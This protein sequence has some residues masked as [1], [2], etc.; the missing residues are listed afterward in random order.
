MRK[1]GL[2]FCSVS[3]SLCCYWWGVIE[4]SGANDDRNEW[5][6]Y[7]SHFENYSHLT[8]H[9]FQAILRNINGDPNADYSWTTARQFF[10]CRQFVTLLA[11]CTKISPWSAISHLE[12]PKII[13][14]LR[15][16]IRKTMFFLFLGHLKPKFA[17]SCCFS[18]SN[19]LRQ[20]K[21]KRMKEPN[22][23]KSALSGMDEVKSIH[24]TRTW[25]SFSTRSPFTR[26]THE[27]YSWGN[28]ARKNWYNAFRGR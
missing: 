26:G 1:K 19:S 27:S 12:V 5:T 15:N 20:P 25:K 16:L 23:R 7:F 13:T 17:N 4:N 8:G 9:L 10:P 22:S 11:R 24:K 2:D 3:F 18:A 6:A 14:T 21:G 28:S